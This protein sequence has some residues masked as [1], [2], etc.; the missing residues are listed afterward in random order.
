MDRRALLE[1][2]RA[3]HFE[4]GDRG[5]AV[6]DARR[7]ARFLSEH[8]ARRIVGVGSA[9]DPTRPFT[10]RSDVDLVVEG[11]APRR[12]YSLSARAAAMTAFA[13]DLIPTESASPALLCELDQRGVDL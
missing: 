10:H 7:I 13:L 3:T 5:L 6:S 8:G 9:F 1:H 4:S 2:I 12:F 11:I